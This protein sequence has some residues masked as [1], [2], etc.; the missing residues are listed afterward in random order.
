[1]RRDFINT[2]YFIKS[3]FLPKTQCVLILSLKTK[4]T[5]AL[6]S[7]CRNINITI[8]KS[9]FENLRNSYFYFQIPEFLVDAVGTNL[10]GIQI[11]SRTNRATD[12]KMR[13]NC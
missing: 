4:F 1:M 5:V 11:I 3:H 7:R 9:V 2:L 13:P 6:M 10:A 8:E 12:I